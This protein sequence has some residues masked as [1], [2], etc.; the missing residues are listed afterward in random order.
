MTGQ[1]AVDTLVY[2][3]QRILPWMTTIGIPIAQHLF[4]RWA[5]SLEMPNKL[6]TRRYREKWVLYNKLAG[7]STRVEA[8]EKLMDVWITQGWEP[9]P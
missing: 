9:R 8:F 5:G 6:D 1:E 7:N 3:V 4:S 2:F